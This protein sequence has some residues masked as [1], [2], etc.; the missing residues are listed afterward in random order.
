MVFEP[1]IVRAAAGGPD[2]DV[3]ATISPRKPFDRT[4]IAARLRG[5]TE[6]SSSAEPDA[7]GLEEPLQ[8]EDNVL[9]LFQDAVGLRR[10]PCGSPSAGRTGSSRRDVAGPGKRDVAGEGLPVAKIA[11]VEEVDPGPG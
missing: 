1:Q 5:S 3:E 7:F 8:Q 4:I 2:E 9:V 10:P 11:G 6:D